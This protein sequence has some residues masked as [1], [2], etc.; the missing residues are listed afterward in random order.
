M[1]SLVV[2][3]TPQALPRVAP[4]MP[5]YTVVAVNATSTSENLQSGDSA[6]GPWTTIATVEAG[7]AAEVTLDK[8]FVRL[9]SAGSLIL[10]G[11]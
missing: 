5:N 4:F 9:D 10:L 8:P 1:R 11:N 6:T 2:T 3:N 7:Q